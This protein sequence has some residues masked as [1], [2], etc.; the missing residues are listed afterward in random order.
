MDELAIVTG[1]DGGMGRVVTQAVAQAGY[2]VVLAC[3]DPARGH[4]AARQIRTR[5]PEA[6][7]EIHPIDL[8]SF[9]STAAFAR[10]IAERP[11]T[12]RLLVNNAGTLGDRFY[13]TEDGLERTVSV[14]Y[15]APYL[16]TRL[17]LPRM[18]AGSR[19][20]NTVS[21]TYAIGKI[22]ACFFERGR[23][24]SFRRIPVYSNTKLALLWFTLELAERT[25]E[26]GITVNAADPGIVDTD[27]ITMHQWFD[28][29]TD[30]LFRPLIRTPE[31][32]AATAVR[33]ALSEE[34][35]SISGACFAGVRRKRLPARLRNR[36]DR[37]RLWEAT[38][39]VVAPFL[40]PER[41]K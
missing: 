3:L 8:A 26:L 7:L 18:Q 40:F 24:G 6:R 27:M 22:P 4:E 10:S 32:G 5:V 33:L 13:R 21:C 1:A 20:V 14:N 29:L 25:R 38:E 23:N 12:V 31:Q 2:R 15:A 36:A 41:K 11:E 19:I 30:L 35:G 9:A 17:M 37:L 28:P 34:A 16:L 39:K